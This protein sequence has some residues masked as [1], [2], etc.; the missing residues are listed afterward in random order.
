MVTVLLVAAPVTFPVVHA[1]PRASVTFA[2]FRTFSA[3]VAT[4]SPVTFAVPVP[5][6]VATVTVSVVPAYRWRG[7]Q[8]PIFKFNPAHNRTCQ[9]RRQ[10]DIKFKE[11]VDWCYMTSGV[12]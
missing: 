1:V 6:A 12:T 2:A 7:W 3:A 11:T 10:Y 9:Q 4:V 5:V 8:V